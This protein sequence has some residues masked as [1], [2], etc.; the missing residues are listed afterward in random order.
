MRMELTEELVRRIIGY[1]DMWNPDMGDYGYTDP[2]SY[3][4]MKIKADC[5]PQDCHGNCMDSE[6]VAGILLDNPDTRV[7]F[8]TPDGKEYSV[9]DVVGVDIMDGIIAL[10]GVSVDGIQ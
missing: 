4:L 7:M 5:I 8:R 6:T 9:T 10:T 2:A 3:A 1:A